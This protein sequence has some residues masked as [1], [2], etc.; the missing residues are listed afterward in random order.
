VTVLFNGQAEKNSLAQTLVEAY[1]VCPSRPTKGE[2][3]RWIRELKAV[4]EIR[5]LDQSAL[6]EED[7]EQID[8][9]FGTAWRQGSRR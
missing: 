8:A 4:N 9:A 7:A 1:R 3:L 5:R 2:I 6:S